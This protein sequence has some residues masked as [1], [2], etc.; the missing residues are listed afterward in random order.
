MA[1][2]LTHFDSLA[3]GEELTHFVDEDL[4]V[5]GIPYRFTPGSTFRRLMFEAFPGYGG[6][7]YTFTFSRRPIDE[8]AWLAHGVI[9]EI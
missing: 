6:L 4:E 9:R 1:L 8:A 3:I 2:E 5:D 7:N